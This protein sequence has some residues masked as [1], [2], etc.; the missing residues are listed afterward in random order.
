MITVKKNLGYL[1]LA[2][3]ILSGCSDSANQV[4]AEKVEE[5]SSEQQELI[6]VYKKNIEENVLMVLYKDFYTRFVKEKGEVQINDDLIAVYNEAIKKDIDS[7][8]EQFLEKKNW[9]GEEFISA[10]NKEYISE[11]ELKYVEDSKKI[12]TDFIENFN[13]KN[14]DNSSYRDINTYGYLKDDKEINALYVYA[15]ALSYN[16][17]EGAF[18]TLLQTVNPYYSKDMGYEIKEYIRIKGTSLS[19]WVQVYNSANGTKLTDKGEG[20]VD[21]NPTI[22]MTKEE[23]ENSTWGKPDSINR[24]VTANSIHEQWVYPNYK[25]LYFEDGIMTSFQD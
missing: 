12:L 13:E 2:A 25:Y 21:Y 19:E 14:I 22:G 8:V 20:I 4:E 17:S 10:E 9:I 11:Q 18:K 1:L 7:G 6:K 3:T 5:V 23:V 16:D 24:T 15:E